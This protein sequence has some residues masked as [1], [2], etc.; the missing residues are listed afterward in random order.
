MKTGSR[1][2]KRITIN[3]ISGC[4][5]LDELREKM[6]KRLNSE[7]SYTST[8]NGFSGGSKMKK[9]KTSENVL[10]KVMNRQQSGYFADAIN[11]K[12]HYAAYKEVPSHLSFCLKEIVPYCYLQGF[13]YGEMLGIETS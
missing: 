2:S 13:V 3:L 12:S 11:K 1:E 6:S 4:N 10:L 7:I 9:T 8:V 5:K